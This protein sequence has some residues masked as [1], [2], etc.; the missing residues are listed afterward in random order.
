MKTKYALFLILAAVITIGAS[1]PIITRLTQLFDVRITAPADGEVLEYNAA[2]GRWRNGPGS[3]IASSVTNLPNVTVTNDAWFLSDVF[4]GYNLWVTNDVFLLSELDVDGEI[5]GENANFNGPVAAASFIQ[6]T[7]TL[8]DLLATK[9]DSD[10]L[11]TG[12]VGDLGAP[13]TN[14]VLSAFDNLWLTR[15]AT[16]GVIDLEGGAVELD[17]NTLPAKRINAT[18]SLSMTFANPPTA[19]N[20]FKGL[21]AKLY[22][23][24]ESYIALAWPDGCEP[25]TGIELTNLVSGYTAFVSFL[26]DGSKVWYS[27]ETRQTD[28]LP[29]AFGG[30][31]RSSLTE[32]AVMVGAGTGPIK[33]LTAAQGLSVS[34]NELVGW[35]K[36][37]KLTHT[38]DDVVLVWSIPVPTNQSFHGYAD[39]RSSGG[40]GGMLRHEVYGGFWRNADAGLAHAYTNTVSHGDTGGNAYWYTN[41]NSAAL[42]VVGIDSADWR[43][44]AGIRYD[45]MDNPDVADPEYTVLWSESFEGVGREKTYAATTGTQWD[46]D[47]TAQYLYGAQSGYHTNAAERHNMR[48]TTITN[49]TQSARMSV[50]INAWP[51]VDGAL[52]LMLFGDSASSYQAQFSITSTGKLRAT[53]W[54]VND[55]T[56]ESVPTNAWFNVWAE[57]VTDTTDNVSMKVGFSTDTTKPTSGDSYYASAATTGR[58][59]TPDRILFPDVLNTAYDDGEVWIDGV[60][61]I[62]G[63]YADLPGAYP[64]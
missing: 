62:D 50:R 63:E 57:M 3:G 51:K 41:D 60:L 28:P 42:Y 18:N 8:D 56:T 26:W 58:T 36:I 53:A 5:T 54:A 22:A 34:T 6:G 47:N 45:L 10:V 15:A 25:V 64:E 27:Y 19:T 1:G 44:W 32:N 46:F 31:G 16:W 43:T 52:R 4:M 55:T 21:P 9:A 33:L 61:I 23:D 13:G 17:W 37:E 49:L 40:A 24:S 30:T 39:V 38:N 59:F 2:T 29:D 48:T 11:D 14:T 7:D 35:D 12:S 20:E